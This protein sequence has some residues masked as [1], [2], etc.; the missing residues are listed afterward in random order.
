VYQTG[1][2]EGKK[3]RGDGEE[4]RV[5]WFAMSRNADYEILERNSQAA[6]QT[7]ESGWS[8]WLFRLI[9]STDSFTR[10]CVS[11]SLSAYNRP[12][13]RSDRDTSSFSV[14]F[15]WAVSFDRNSA[16]EKERTFS[17]KGKAETRG[18]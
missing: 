12:S 5:L 1:G 2:E 13:I 15:A 8:H 9:C 11:A 14:P 18:R 4:R 7:P 10:C 16:E 3:R 6:A 17:T